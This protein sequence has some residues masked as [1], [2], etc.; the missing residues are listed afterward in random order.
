MVKF[1]MK[2]P[3][4][5]GKDGNAKEATEYIEI[6][7]L[8][9]GKD[10]VSRP[11]TDD[12]RARYGAAYAEFKKEQDEKG[13]QETQK[14]EGDSKDPLALTPDGKARAAARRETPPKAPHTGRTGGI[15]S[16][17][18]DTDTR[19]PQALDRAEGRDQ[20]RDDSEA[21]AGQRN[22]Q[23]RGE[24]D[25]DAAPELGKRETHSKKANR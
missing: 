1:E 20:S 24:A 8:N 12:D 10:V 4:G 18:L 21:L 15:E 17:A 16:G 19:D 5:K 11:A 22:I 6:G 14:R 7:G 9:T 13:E 23:D 25:E 3:P 2:V